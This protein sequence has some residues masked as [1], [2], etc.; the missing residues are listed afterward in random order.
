MRVV[1]AITP[2]HGHVYPTLPLADALRRAGHTTTY[3]MIDASP[4]RETIEE[5]GHR[6]VALPPS[7][8]EQ[9]ARF[10]EAWSDLAG[11]DAEQRE[12]R[13]LARLFVPL[14]EPSLYPLV[15]LLRDDGVDLVVHELTAFAGPLAAA[16]CSIPSVNHG[17]GFGFPASA[18]GA[19]DAMADAWL[20]HD[21]E[22]DAMAG[23]Y[24]TLHLEVFPP[25]LPNP[26]LGA[27]HPAQVRRVRPV[28]LRSPGGAVTPTSSRRR[29]VAT[30]GT[31]FDDDPAAWAAIE[32]A[33][34]RLGPAVEVVSLRPG[35]GF[36]PVGDVVDGAA[37][38]VAHG[39]AGTVLAALAAGVPL[40]LLP[41]GADQWNI[42]E[43]AAACGAASVVEPDAAVIEAAVRAALDGALDHGVALVRREIEAMPPP[44]EL[45]EVLEAVARRGPD[46]QSVSS[47]HGPAT[48]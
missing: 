26:I 2:G 23:I 39:G 33:L 47:P 41:R 14:V 29:V 31:V 18:R 45:V 22:P 6:F 30:L 5:R 42:A 1:F 43:A 11:L 13:G 28:A 15:E 10:A 17:T 3:A 7:Q 38:V 4:L 44:A 32:Q 34:G 19:G 40:V 37:V 9:Q 8:A 27:L 35:A 36:V 12:V 25:S 20:A 21:L 24:R 16:M 48:S 46:G